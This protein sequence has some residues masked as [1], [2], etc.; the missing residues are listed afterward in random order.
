MMLTGGLLI[1]AGIVLTVV[2][3]LRATPGGIY[4]FYWGAIVFGGYRFTRGLYMD[5]L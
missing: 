5:D 1:V 2:S 4:Y 3:Y